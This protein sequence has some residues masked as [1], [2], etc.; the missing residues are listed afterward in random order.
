MNHQQGFVVG[1]SSRGRPIEGTSDHR[2]VIDHRE[3]VVQLVATGKAGSAD[4]FEGLIQRLIT[5][6]HLEV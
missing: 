5:R 1:V 2:F 6:F 4:A 3:L